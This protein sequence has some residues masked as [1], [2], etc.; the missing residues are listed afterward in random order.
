MT[1]S[2]KDP[3]AVISNEGPLSLSGQSSVDHSHS[4]KEPAEEPE[5]ISF[6]GALRIPVS[7]GMEERA[8]PEQ[9][10]P[11]TR[12]RKWAN[13]TMWRRL[14]EGGSSDVPS[15]PPRAWWSSPCACSLPSW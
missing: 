2:E 4:P 8:K 14:G 9:L 15:S 5:A 11:S 7:A 1:I 13:P 3:E 6:L 12:G 10:R